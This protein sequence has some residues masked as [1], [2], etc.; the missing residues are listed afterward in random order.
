MAFFKMW[1]NEKLPAK[2]YNCFSATLAYTKDT[3]RF[4]FGFVYLGIFYFIGTAIGL[5][6]FLIKSNKKLK[7]K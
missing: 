1:I 3:T 7:A 5:A 2:G 6:F 4:D